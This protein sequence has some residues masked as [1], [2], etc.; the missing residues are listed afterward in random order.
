MKLA[1]VICPMVTPL[2]GNQNIDEAGTRRLV[3]RLIANGVNGLFLLGTMGEFPML[4]ESEKERLV[5]IAADENRGRV[6]LLVN[7]SA[8][9]VRKTELFLGKA[10]E[11][12]ADLIVLTPPYYYNTRDKR[13]IRDYYRYFSRNSD[14]PLFIYDAGKYTNNPIPDDT[15]IELSHEERIVGFKGQ[16][17]SHLPVF[18]ELTGRDDFALFQGDEG[19]LDLALRLGADGLVPG[20]SSLA[21]ERCVRLYREALEG[22]FAAAAAIQRELAEIQ[23]VVYGATGNH[24]GNG[25]KYA[26]SLLGI[27][28]EHIATTLL[29]ISDADKAEIRR[30]M[31][32]YRIS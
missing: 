13:E 28:E 6:P 26:L 4:V 21:I 9:G 11:A 3:N 22:Q 15:L 23:R 10:L 12:G 14:K 19:A 17:F 24:W 32:K 27:C 5:K 30:V 8:E 29:P 18:R 31:E 2:D 1:G 7:V 25:Q 16:L 20:I